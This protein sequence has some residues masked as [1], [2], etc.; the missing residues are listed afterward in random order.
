MIVEIHYVDRDWF[1]VHPRAQCVKVETRATSS[2][3]GAYMYT[4]GVLL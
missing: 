2:S 3:R 4:L 1:I